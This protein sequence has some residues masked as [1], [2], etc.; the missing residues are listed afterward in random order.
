MYDGMF[1]C[2]GIKLK[3]VVHDVKEQSV[4]SP[5]RAQ[6][7]LMILSPDPVGVAGEMFTT[8]PESPAV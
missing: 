5:V 8:D 6:H 7:T 2:S 3:R 1:D 4:I